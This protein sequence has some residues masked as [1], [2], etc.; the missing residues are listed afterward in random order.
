MKHKCSNCGHSLTGHCALYSSAC[1]TAMFNGEEPYRW[2]SVVEGLDNSFRKI[3][4]E[5][6]KAGVK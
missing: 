4:K 6:A 1:V 5:E 3:L 2:I